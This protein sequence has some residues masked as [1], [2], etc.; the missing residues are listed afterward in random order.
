MLKWILLSSFVLLLFASTFAQQANSRMQKALVNLNDSTKIESIPFISNSILVLDAQLLDTIHPNSYQ[1]END[2]L[3]WKSN[4]PKEILIHYKLLPFYISENTFLLDTNLIAKKENPDNLIEYEIPKSKEENLSN[5]LNYQG[6]FSRGVNFGNN[7]DLVL[8]SGL[9]LQMEGLVG[10]D[11]RIKA[12]I[13]DE[14]IPLQPEGNTQNLKEFDRIFI[15]VEKNKNQLIAGDYDLSTKS[16][17]LNYNKNLQGASFQNQLDTRN[18]L[19]SNRVSIAISKG[20]FKRQK[21]K[22]LEGNQGPYKLIGNQKETFIIILA[23]T[24]KVF[25]DGELLIRGESKDY[26]IDYNQG[27]ILFTPDIPINAYSRIVVEFEYATQNY[28]KSLFAIDN[29]F[30]NDKWKIDFHLFSEQESKNTTGLS[31]LSSSEKQQLADAGDSI[32]DQFFSGIQSRIDPLNPIFYLIKDTIINTILF[33][34]ILVYNPS[35]NSEN[36]NVK[37]TNVGFGNG[38]YIRSNESTNGTI[39]QWIAPDEKGNLQ[40]N[41]EPIV[42]LLAPTKHQIYNLDATYKISKNSHISSEISMSNFDKNRFSKKDKNDN[43]GMAI[44]SEYQTNA[45]L[46]KSKLWQLNSLISYEFSDKKYKSYSPF[47][48][49]EFN[50]DWNIKD[51]ESPL[52]SHFINAKFDIFRDRVVSISYGINSFSQIDYFKGIQQ[53]GNITLQK[54][55]WL[56]VS[57]G[58]WLQTSSQHESTQFIKPNL[59]LSKSF[60]KINDWKIGMLLEQEKNER[61]RN[62]TLSLESFYFNQSKWF[63]ESKKTERLSLGSHF[64]IREDFAPKNQTFQKN[65]QSSEYK[66]FGQWKPK[67]FFRIEGSWLQ[68]NVDIENLD[69]TEQI[70]KKYQIGQVNLNY[71]PWKGAIQISSNYEIGGG[72]EAK[73]AYRYLEVKAGQGV[74]Q[75]IDYNQDGTQQINEFEIAPYPDLAQFVRIILPTQE[76]IAT[77]F[78]KFNQ[79]FA[80]IPKARWYNSKSKPVQL[81]NYFSTQSTYFIHRRSNNKNNQIDWNPFDFRQNDSLLIADNQSVRNSL[82]FNR[83]SQKFNA[84][85]GFTNNQQKNILVTG[86]ESISLKETF[87]KIQGRVVENWNIYLEASKGSKNQISENFIQ[88]NYKLDII[89]TNLKIVNQWKE[90]WRNSFEL[91]YILKDNT[92]STNPNSIT[93]K[94]AKLSIQYNQTDNL[95]IE[96]MLNF[97]NVNYIGDLNSPVSYELLDGLQ[98]GNNF[99]WGLQIHKKISKFLFVNMGYN[100][101]KGGSSKIIHLGN[102]QMIAQF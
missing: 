7:H 49:P 97:T 29:K 102:L 89:K 58:Q 18:G 91:K 1:I 69:W 43:I 5:D 63:I 78:L 94:V 83:T 93:Q 80:F 17:F 25:L 76:Y 77:N 54:N 95:S 82:F 96:S 86:F 84:E 71:S 79:S 57:N 65:I 66:I 2:Y 11:I 70:P 22:V 85:F 30:E 13:S 73:I 3:I 99:I 27:E 20:E 34:D 59:L 45:S 50:R 19:I 14:N 42:K 64:L 35:K 75:W 47:R 56:L 44:F 68:R 28:L 36:R 32:G 41:Y 46:G 51:I 40:G 88:K 48:N 81:L 101:R 38:N 24:E 74:Y 62:D 31:E 21:L 92:L 15:Q 72:Q 100:G 61:V 9:N 4:N 53:N 52:S 6:S 16:H 39:F 26:I 55:G 98:N 37:F 23:N 87:L 33:S 8:N 67:S 90:K 10:D 60:S 12:A